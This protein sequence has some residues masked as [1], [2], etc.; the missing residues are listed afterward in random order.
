MKLYLVA[1]LSALVF[2]ITTQANDSTGSRVPILYPDQHLYDQKIIPGVETLY[3]SLEGLKPGSRYEIRISYPATSPTDFHLEIVRPL[4]LSAPLSVKPPGRVPANIEKIEVD[5]AELVVEGPNGGS[6]PSWVRVWATY[7]GFSVVP[8]AAERPVI[9]NIVAEPLVLGSVPHTAL[10][11]GAL[12]LCC[13]IACSAGCWYLWST[14]PG[15]EWLRFLLM[16]P[17]HPD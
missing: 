11:M 9:F 17:P 16:G 10:R 3:Y 14:R 6:V 1:F 15:R 12:V 13:V 7:N 4:T 8:G 2:G 5:P